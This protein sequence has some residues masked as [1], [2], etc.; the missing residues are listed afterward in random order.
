MKVEITILGLFLKITLHYSFPKTMLD[1]LTQHSAICLGFGY[2][3]QSQTARTPLSLSPPLSVLLFLPNYCR[4]SCPIRQHRLPSCR[5]AF[6]H[7]A[8]PSGC[9]GP[10][11]P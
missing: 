6:R 11:S 4:P 1:E 10:C 5:Q 2:K 7:Q 3:S 8:I 9:S